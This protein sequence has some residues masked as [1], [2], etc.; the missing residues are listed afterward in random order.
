MIILPDNLIHSDNSNHPLSLPSLKSVPLHKSLS[1]GL[2]VAIIAFSIFALVRFQ[3]KNSGALLFE[4]YF[5]ARPVT[6]YTTQRSLAAGDTNADASTMRQGIAYHQREDYDLALV[7]LRAYLEGNPE[8]TTNEPFLLA[9][10]AAIATG[11]YAEGAELL[12]QIPTD[13]PAFGL[14]ARWHLALLQLRAENKATAAELLRQI[15]AEGGGNS[16]PV[17]ALLKHF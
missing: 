4:R 12:E 1:I 16:Y 11:R 14:A 13:D 10:T 8:P 15:A 6:G 17:Q 5:S 7:A 2:L 3:V 9:A